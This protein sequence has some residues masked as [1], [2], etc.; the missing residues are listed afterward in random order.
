MYICIYIYI[1]AHMCICVCVCVYIYIYIHINSNICVN[2]RNNL[3]LP[4]MTAS[5]TAG[6]SPQWMGMQLSPSTT[7]TCVYIYNV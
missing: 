7:L 3:L 2:D 5:G 6:K 1:Y 4:L